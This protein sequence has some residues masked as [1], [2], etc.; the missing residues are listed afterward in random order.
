MTPIYD[1]THPHNAVHCAMLQ[2]VI[3][4]APKTV[5]YGGHYGGGWVDMPKDAYGI[6]IVDW[7]ASHTFRIKPP[8]PVMVTRTV[9][10]PAPMTVAPANGTEYLV[11][12]ANGVYSYTWT[13]DTTEL[14][15]LAIGICH[16]TRE[17]AQEHWN[18]Y[19]GAQK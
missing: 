6:S 14:A 12:H 17:A 9:T 13:G 1:K 15:W 4:G 11:P 5:Q 7:V 16:L 19:Y 2:S 10:Y 8:E 18:A 3:D